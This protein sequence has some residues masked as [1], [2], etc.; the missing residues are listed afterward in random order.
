MFGKK[1]EKWKYIGE[2]YHLGDNGE[3]IP[4][5]AGA[6]FVNDLKLIEGEQ[7]LCVKESG[8]QDTRYPDNRE[9]HEKRK[10]LFLKSEKAI[11]IMFIIAV[12]S[13]SFC[14]W[15]DNDHSRWY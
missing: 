1:E 2:N 12:R 9:K 11:N 7:I 6:K 3:I 13:C 14:H 8:K 4:H 15:S 10:I 5:P